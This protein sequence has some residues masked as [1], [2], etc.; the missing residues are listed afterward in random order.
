M[1]TK[2]EKI[3]DEVAVEMCLD[4]ETGFLKDDFE[5][6]VSVCEET[7]AECSSDDIETCKMDWVHSIKDKFLYEVIFKVHPGY[8]I[9]E[10]HGEE[11]Y[12]E[13]YDGCF[14]YLVN[15]TFNR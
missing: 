9:D 6:D 12:E 5:S 15:R 4:F 13:F 7:L 2:L 3:Y 14:A 10:E 1:K 8:E 11:Y